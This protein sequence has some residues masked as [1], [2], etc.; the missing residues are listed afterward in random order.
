MV[1]YGD[2]D[3]ASVGDRLSGGQYSVGDRRIIWTEEGANVIHQLK[4]DVRP[5]IYRLML[6]QSRTRL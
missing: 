5:R 2:V 3:V 6:D 1:K 4:R